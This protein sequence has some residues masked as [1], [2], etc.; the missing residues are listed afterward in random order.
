MGN[1]PK[2]QCVSSGNVQYPGDA[3]FLTFCFSSD[4]WVFAQM[5]KIIFLSLTSNS[6][7][8]YVIAGLFP[9][10]FRLNWLIIVNIHGFVLL[11]PIE[12]DWIG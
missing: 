10:Y 2:E 9:L 1:Y 12:E 5:R 8:N 7:C 11:V 4:Y 3:S 6:T